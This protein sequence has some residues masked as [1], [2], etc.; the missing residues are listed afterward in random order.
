[1]GRKSQDLAQPLNASLPGPGGSQGKDC[2]VKQSSSGKCGPASTLAGL[3]HWPGAA[4]GDGAPRVNAAADPEGR[5]AG[6]S[7]AVCLGHPAASSLEGS[8]EQHTSRLPPAPLHDS[9]VMAYLSLPPPGLLEGKGLCSAHHCVPAQGMA[10]TRSLMNSCILARPTL[11]P[12]QSSCFPCKRCSWQR[13]QG[14]KSS[15]E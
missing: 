8:S 14:T 6:G 13:K 5:A 2:P 11:P 4:Q 3:S 12:L 10:Y 9:L 15:L 7:G 1:M